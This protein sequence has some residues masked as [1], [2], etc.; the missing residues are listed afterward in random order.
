MRLHP[1]AALAQ[2]LG[3]S[4][5]LFDLVA[6]TGFAEQA[7]LNG[8]NDLRNDFQ[9]AVHKHVERVS[10]DAFGRILDR[11]DAVIRAVFADFA[12]NVS[13]GLLWRVVKARAKSANGGLV[14]ESG[15]GSEIRDGERFLE[16]ESAG[17]DFAINGAQGFAGHWAGIQAADA[18]QDSTFAV[19]SVDFFTGFKFDFADGQNVFGA[20]VEELDDLPIQ[21]VNRF[22]MFGN[23]Q[24]RR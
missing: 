8:Q 22:A 19:W 13:D 7:M 4:V 11:D 6:A 23:V 16:R 5:Q 20:F 2:G 15:F 3:M 10:D 21:P 1:A 24:G 18:I 12:E 17:H 14:S 9:I